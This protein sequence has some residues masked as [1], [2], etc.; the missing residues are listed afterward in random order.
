MAT[1]L[2]FCA[3]EFDTLAA[4]VKA[5]DF[6]LA[7]DGG[8]R[9]LEKLNITPDGIIGDFDSLGFVPEGAQVFPV[10][11]DDTDAMLAARKGLELGFREFVIY[12]GL[13]GQRLDHTV[14]NFQTLQFLA[15]RGAT[16]YLVGAREIVTVIKEETIRFPATA[17]GIVS[18]FCLGPDAEGVTLRGL[19]YPL[20]NGRL[21]SGFPLGVS[22]HF[23][24]KVGEITVEKGSLLAI[25]ER[26]NGFP[27]R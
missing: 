15:D 13:G 20:E 21:T 4:P 27:E 2:I 19:Y 5:G 16:G 11:K 24:G 17:E 8:L 9:H 14:A 23:T 25:W 10:E 6:I 26:K 12:G 3:A 22:N 7:A 18:L 1:C